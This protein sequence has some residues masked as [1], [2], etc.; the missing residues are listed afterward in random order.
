MGYRLGLLVTALSLL[1]TSGQARGAVVTIEN[2]K[3]RLTRV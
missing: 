2:P 1:F 3:T